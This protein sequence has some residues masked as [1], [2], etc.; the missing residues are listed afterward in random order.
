MYKKIAF[1]FIFLILCINKGSFEQLPLLTS[2]NLTECS[3]LFLTKTSTVTSTIYFTSVTTSTIITSSLPDSKS[4]KPLLENP[5]SVTPHGDN[6]KSKLFNIAIIIGSLLTGCIIN[7]IG[8]LMYWWYKKKFG[9]M[10]EL[11]LCVV[12]MV[13][14]MVAMCV[15]EI[16]F[17]FMNIIYT[18]A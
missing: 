8:F 5:T 7:A 13:I 17:E 3:N 1:I 4:V 14:M 18:T 15:E 12:V 2:E 16:L 10:V 11:Y 9:F 6:N